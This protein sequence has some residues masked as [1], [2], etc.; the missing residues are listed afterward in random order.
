MPVK[1]CDGIP[2]FYSNSVSKQD[3]DYYVS[4]NSSTSGYGVDTT[5]LVVRVENGYRDVYYILSGDHREGYHACIDLDD[6]LRYLHD[7]KDLLHS[8]SDPIEH[9]R[10]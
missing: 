5:A 6:C 1:F 8:M 3:R 10:P 2:V 9:A 4:Y 7:H